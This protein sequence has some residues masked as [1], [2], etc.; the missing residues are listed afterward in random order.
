LPI[1][2]EFYVALYP[3]EGA[4]CGGFQCRVGDCRAV[5]RTEKGIRLHAGVCHGVRWQ[6]PLFNSEPDP[7]KAKDLPAGVR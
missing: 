1:Q 2:S 5:T 7:V 6:K 4:P 3:P